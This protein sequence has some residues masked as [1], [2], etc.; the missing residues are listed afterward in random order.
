VH[1]ATT[2]G[3]NPAPWGA[4]PVL[5]ERLGLCRERHGAA[6]PGPGGAVGTARTARPSRKLWLGHVVGVT[7]QTCTTYCSIWAD[8]VLI[9]G[10]ENAVAN[11][12]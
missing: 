2:S 6:R 8:A 7:W 1:G 10:F 12:R 4:G 5:S 9:W 3:L 11:V